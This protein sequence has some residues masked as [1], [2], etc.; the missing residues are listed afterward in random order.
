MFAGVISCGSVFPSATFRAT[1]RQMLAISRSR[2]RTPASR[3]YWPMRT[4][5]AGSVKT[6]CFSV[7]PCSES[8]RGM[9]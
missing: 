2:L 5:T 9:R 8:C 7:T 4:R 1:F 3:V 6:T